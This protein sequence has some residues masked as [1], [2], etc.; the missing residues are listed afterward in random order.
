[1][2]RGAQKR[3]RAAVWLCATHLNAT[4]PASITQDNLKEEHKRYDQFT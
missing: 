1:M 3:N 2:V 4:L